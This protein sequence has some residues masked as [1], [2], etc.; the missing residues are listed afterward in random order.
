MDWGSLAAKVA[1]KVG[2]KLLSGS[3][4]DTKEKAAVQLPNWDDAFEEM[5]KAN[6]GESVGAPASVDYNKMVQSWTDSIYSYGRK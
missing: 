1:V 5:R 4:K 6:I 3:K 2:S